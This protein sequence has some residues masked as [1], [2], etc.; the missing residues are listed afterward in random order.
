MTGSFFRVC[1]YGAVSLSLDDQRPHIQCCID[2]AEAYAQ[3]HGG[4][5][6][7]ID[8]A[9]RI[10]GG[11]RIKQDRVSLVFTSGGCLVPVG[12]FDTLRLEKDVPATWMYRNFVVNAIFDERLK[13]GGNSIAAKYVT[14]GRIEAFRG[15]CG[16]D[17]I[18]METYHDFGIDARITDYRGG[19][20]CAYV[21]ALA[22]GN[23]RSDILKL[24]VICGG[25]T[26]PGMDGLFVDGFCHTITADRFYAVTVGRNALTVQNTIGDHIPSFLKFLDFQSDYAE[27]CA[28]DALSASDISFFSPYMHGSKGWNNLN[29]APGVEDL[30]ILGGRITSAAQH[31]AFIF[32]D[33]CLIEGTNFRHNSEKTASV[34]SGIYLGP[35]AR[36]TRINAVRSGSSSQKWGVAID[37]SSDRFNV[38]GNDFTGNSVTGVYNGAGTGQTKIVS[39]NIY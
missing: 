21:K 30:K 6:V 5:D 14:E 13:T 22:P 9:Y 10:E 37:Q 19:V 27:R 8:G 28:V 15:Q 34:Y 1:D 33:T 35:S 11:L 16:W 12:N 29:A 26:A 32:S 23:A 17:G 7:I 36:N 24:D 3:L 18:S 4:A 38:C 20:G 2:A 25:S 39:D 31:G